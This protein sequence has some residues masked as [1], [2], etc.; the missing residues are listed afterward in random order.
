M[1]HT[2]TI[3]VEPAMLRRAWDAWCFAGGR[4][5]RL[6][7]AFVLMTG[8]SAYLLRTDPSDWETIAIVTC[9]CLAVVFI[10]TAYVMG[11]RR[12]EAKCKALGDGRATYTFTDTRI[13]AASALGST[14]L[15]W[16]VLKEVRGYK[17]LVLLSLQG[18]QYSTLPASQVP[19]EALAFLIDHA[20]AAGAKIANL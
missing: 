4:G 16:S 1:S 12:I 7:G 17:D 20:R 19:P 14:S 3:Q 11:L 18:A 10:G 5:W 9:A 13:E 2:F 8:A 6:L 15:A